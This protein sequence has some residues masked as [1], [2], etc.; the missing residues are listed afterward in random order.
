MIVL[1]T[2]TLEE[3]RE[4]STKKLQAVGFSTKPGSIAKL[5]LNIINQSVADLYDT[6][7]VNHLRSFLSTSY[8]DALDEIGAL[9]HCKRNSLELDDD[10]RYR[11]SKQC[12]TLASSNEMAIRLA[13]LCTEGVEDVVLKNHAIGSGSFGVIV[14]T[15]KEYNTNDVLA[16]VKKRIDE[17]V[18]YGIRYV[19]MT[20][21]LSKIK[22][23]VRLQFEQNIGDLKKQ[24]IRYQ[25]KNALLD[26]FTTIPIGES[27]LIDK[28]TQV[29][30]NA[31]S[32]IQGYQTTK[33]SID[34][35]KAMF[36]NQACRWCE[37]FYI[38][39]DADNIIVL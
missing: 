38:S 13:V 27:I 1:N 5:F 6:L 24:E 23:S 21:T 11:I 29:I 4:D 25:V 33:F 30:M 17:T 8:D 26:Y 3:L 15:G 37:Q 31:S 39:S 2:K 22:I 35:E 14:V 10:Y 28:I 9:L 36:V 32:F 20:P 18:G 16:I 34:G 19:L 12:Y 7:T